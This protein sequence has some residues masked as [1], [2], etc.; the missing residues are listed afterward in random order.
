MKYYFAPMEGIGGYIYR[1]AHAK[2]FRACDKY[3]APFISPT[4]DTILKTREKED[5]APEHND[6]IQ[7]VPQILTNKAE[8]FLK[9]ADVL[10]ERGYREINLNLGCPSKTVVTKH[11]GAGFLENP[12][13]LAG[14]F[15]E[16]FNEI[17]KSG[18]ELRVSVKTRIGLYEEDEAPQI[19]R[20]FWDYPI[21]ELTVHPRLQEDYYK[22][23]PHMNVFADIVKEAKVPLVYN[24]D[25]NSIEDIRSF[26]QQYPSVPAVMMGRGFYRNPNLLDGEPDRKVLYEFLKELEHNYSEVLPGDKTVLFKLKEIWS[27]LM[28]QFTG[29]EKQWKK[30]K[31][32]Q[33]LKQYDAVVEELFI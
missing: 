32:S 8:Y 12:I 33:N 22:N 14:F 25:L 27:Y 4:Y 10:M 5:V 29:C 26:E 17:D 11:K 9:T 18:R 6:T 15:E 13:M 23:K 7:L 30:I 24:G 19:F 16:L 28:E 1:N 21:A 3:F 2:Y 20:V 31:K